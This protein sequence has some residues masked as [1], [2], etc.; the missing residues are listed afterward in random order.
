[1]RSRKGRARICGRRIKNEKTE[2]KVQMV[3]SMRGGLSV[4]KYMYWEK[5][6]QTKYE[7]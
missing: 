5:R 4:L 2:E 1:M 7:I 6:M 3:K